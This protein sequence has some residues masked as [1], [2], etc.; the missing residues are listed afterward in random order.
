MARWHKAFIRR[1]DDPTPLT[2]AEI[3]EGFACFDTEDFQ[4]GYK[5]FLAK[6]KPEFKAR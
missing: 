2:E 5:A 3:A 4:I 1:M 6:I